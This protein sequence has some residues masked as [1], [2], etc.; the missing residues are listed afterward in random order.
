M[1][2]FDRIRYET[3]LPRYAVSRAA[4]LLQRRKLGT[5]QPDEEDKRWKPLHITLLGLKC[6]ERIDLDIARHLFRRFHG[7]YA[8][9]SY[10]EPAFH[11]WKATR[12]LD[13]SALGDPPIFGF[14]DPIDS[15]TNL[16]ANQRI[17]MR[18]VEELQRSAK[19]SR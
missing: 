6:Y 15:R 2:S 19:S 14:P 8:A 18:M 4:E 10:Y 11:L 16:T 17:L 12:C 7:D 3:G 9:T 13:F 1:V 5:V